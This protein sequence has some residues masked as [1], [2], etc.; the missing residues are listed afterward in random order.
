MTT[1]NMQECVE[2]CE[3]LRSDMRK[4]IGRFHDADLVKEFLFAKQSG[5][6]VAST[7]PLW[8]DELILEVSARDLVAEC[9]TELSLR[10]IQ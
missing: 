2:T 3:K 5:P 1:Q 8:I 4:E 7:A 10:T 6:E 9:S